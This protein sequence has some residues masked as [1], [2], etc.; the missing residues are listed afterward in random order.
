MA[1][2]DAIWVNIAN[3]FPSD[4]FQF[5]TILT[6]LSADFGINNAF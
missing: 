1:I 4:F 2:D 6:P 3:Q 5:E